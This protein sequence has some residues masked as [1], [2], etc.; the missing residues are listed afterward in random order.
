M[1]RRKRLA[2]PLLF[3]LVVLA[4]AVVAGCAPQQPARDED[5]AQADGNAA[6]AGGAQAE[7]KPSASGEVPTRPL[8]ML[9]EVGELKDRLGEKSLRIV[10]ARSQ[11]DYEA[12]HIPGAVRVDVSRWRSLA[13]SEGG[14]RDAQAWSEILGSLG[15]DPLTNVVVYSDRPTDATRIWWTLKY[16]GLE[17][18]AVLDGGWSYWTESGG[19]QSRAAVEVEPAD[20][21]PEFQP[22]RLAEID[23]LKQSLEREGELTVVDARSQQE[24][25]GT[26]GP[27]ARLG[28]IPGAVHLEWKELLRP[29]GRFKSKDELQAIFEQRNVD[30]QKRAVTYCQSGGRA[31]LDAFALELAGYENVQN[32][33][34]S[35]QEWSA[36]AEAPVE[37]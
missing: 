12:G 34:C 2:A 35:W 14:L 18:A 23:D 19:E 32:Y 13:L 27:G 15:I 29:D 25:E 31:S 4:A 6:Q 20:F 28:R 7:A 17:N 36:D 11:E 24:F 33:Y 3:G 10:D 9:I 26:G 21:Q 30:R 5:A 1:L 37:K 8:E 22:G 16:V